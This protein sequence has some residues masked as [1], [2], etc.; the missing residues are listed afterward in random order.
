M[1]IENDF[2]FYFQIFPCQHWEKH[3]Y[4]KKKKKAKQ[5]IWLRCWT[6]ATSVSKNHEPFTGINLR[7]PEMTRHWAPGPPPH[8]GPCFQLPFPH[9]DTHNGS[10]HP[11]GP[12]HLGTPVPLFPWGLSPASF[13]RRS[14]TYPQS[15]PVWGGQAL[16]SPYFTAFQVYFFSPFEGLWPFPRVKA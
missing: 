5:M 10:S 6:R 3:I 7:V 11:T 9:R 14:S 1:L 8:N 4:G 16:I 13:P 2:V 12:R 15:F